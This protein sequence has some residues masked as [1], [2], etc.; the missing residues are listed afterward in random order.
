MG[1]LRDTLLAASLAAGATIVDES[2]HTF[3]PYDGVS[4]VI[5]ILESHVSIHTWPEHGYAAV[6]IFTCGTSVEPEKAV[7]LLV[8]EL[9]P[10]DSSILEV[11]R[12]IRKPVV[13]HDGS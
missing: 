11:K 10:Q 4:G 8:Q 9:Q 3:P 1:F 13:A 2:F 12:G 6:D 7:D 5:I